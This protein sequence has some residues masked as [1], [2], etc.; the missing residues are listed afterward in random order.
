MSSST[1][2]ARELLGTLGVVIA[3]TVLY[4]VSA[5]MTLPDPPGED[6]PTRA[7]S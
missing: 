7:L 3:F 5:A 4:V 1:R 6:V 2:T